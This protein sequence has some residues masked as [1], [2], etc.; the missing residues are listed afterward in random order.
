MADAPGAAAEVDLVQIEIED[1]VLREGLLDPPRENDLAHFTRV[2]SLRC[3][4][5]TLHHLLGDRAC[6]LR[7][8][9]FAEIG[10]GGAKDR[11][12]V[13]ALMLEERAVFSRDEGELDES[14]DL[15]DWDEASL[16]S[17]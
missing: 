9:A 15:V 6:T 14:R 5:E 12:E 11:H 10:E 7:D 2:G 4:Q 17:E 3:Q 1:F 16:L 8:A 13:D